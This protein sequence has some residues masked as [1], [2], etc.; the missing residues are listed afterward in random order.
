MWNI[1]SEN[2]DFF[3]N[4]IVHERDYLIDFFGFK[5]LERSYLLKIGNKIIERPQYMWLRVSIGIHGTNFKNIKETYDL[6]S[7]KYF[8]HATPTLFNAGTP[9]QQ[10]SSC[11]LLAM[12]DDSIE[13]IYKTLS[14]CAQISKYSGGIGLHI[15]NVRAKDSHISGTNGKTDGIVPMLRV[16]NS[17]ARY[18][19]QSGK[20]NGSFAVYIEPWHADIEEFL[21]LKR[22]MEM[23]S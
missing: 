5:T 14:D 11:Y 17:T 9:R 8:T 7:Q 16:Y 19:N 12:E 6:M 21:E 20:R 22:I 13:G 18:V 2:K 15:H 4:L 3:D 23:K 1:V 10:L